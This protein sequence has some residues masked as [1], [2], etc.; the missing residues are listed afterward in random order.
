MEVTRAVITRPGLA[1]PFRVDVFAEDGAVL[2]AT[3]TLVVDADYLGILDFN[4]LQ[5]TPTETFSGRDTTWWTF[6]VPPG[7]SRLRVDIDGRLE[8]AVQWAR[9]GSVALILEGESLATAEFTTWV[10]P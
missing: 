5:P 2:P 3:V 10:M 7:Q 1:T 9:K 4:G 8:P 6:E